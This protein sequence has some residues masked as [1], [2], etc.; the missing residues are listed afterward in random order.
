MQK[1][2]ITLAI[3][4]PLIDLINSKNFASKI[5]QTNID[6][7]KKYMSAIDTVTHKATPTMPCHNK[8]KY[9]SDKIKNVC[10]AVIFATSLAFPRDRKTLA[11]GM[12]I[13]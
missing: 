8:E 11:E 13:E 3:I 4:D 5:E 1:N 12:P 2:I 10:M 6:F 9:I 7:I